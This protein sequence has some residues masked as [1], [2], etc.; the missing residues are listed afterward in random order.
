MSFA[1]GLVDR[2]CRAR[3]ERDRGWLVAP[4]GDA[5]DPV[6]TLQGQVLDVGLTRFADSQP[7]QAEEHGEGLMSAVELLGGGE[8]HAELG[9]VETASGGGVDLGAAD[10]LGGVRAD[11]AVDVSEP[12]EPAYRREPPVDRRRR[13]PSFL[14]E[15]RQSSVCGW[16]AALTGTSW[17]A[18]HWTKPRRS[19]RYASRVRPL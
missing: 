3:D 14:I 9:A 10:V 13:Q 18:A 7:V 6:A 12:V 5:Q 1:D 17:S 15:P 2:S 19:C 8:E 11:P 16:V 4:A